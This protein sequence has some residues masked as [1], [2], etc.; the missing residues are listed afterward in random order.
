MD[1]LHEFSAKYQYFPLPSPPVLPL[2]SPSLH[3]PSIGL[4]CDERFEHW[5]RVGYSVFPSEVDA[6]ESR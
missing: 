2:V 1:S 5:Y 4:I 6:L 3:M